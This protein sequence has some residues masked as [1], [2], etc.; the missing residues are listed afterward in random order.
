MFLKIKLGAQLQ[1]WHLEMDAF[2]LSFKSSNTHWY[3]V[4]SVGV[5]FV[6]VRRLFLGGHLPLPLLA[7]CQC[8]GTA[9][10]R[11]SYQVPK[12]QSQL[13]SRV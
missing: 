6:V 11:P 13:S 2:L 12:F 5:G 8:P 1:P 7:G 4:H 10:T 9:I 3:I